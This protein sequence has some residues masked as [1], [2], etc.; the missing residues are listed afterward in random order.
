MN[1]PPCTRQTII[2]CFCPLLGSPEKKPVM[3]TRRFWYPL[4]QP[5]QFFVDCSHF[6]STALLD[7]C[8]SQY[9]RCLPTFG[10]FT[11]FWSMSMFLVFDGFHVNGFFLEFND[12]ERG[13][14]PSLSLSRKSHK[15]RTLFWLIL[16]KKSIT[17][18]F[19]RWYPFQI[20]PSVGQLR[21]WYR[22][23]ILCSRK[24]TPQP[25]PR[26]PKILQKREELWEHIIPPV[27]TLKYFRGPTVK[28]KPKH[29]CGMW[30]PWKGGLGHWYSGGRGYHWLSE[31]KLTRIR[32]I[33]ATR[34]WVAE[35]TCMGSKR[36]SMRSV[37]FDRGVTFDCL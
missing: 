16:Q 7:S 32:I 10:L 4:P 6:E 1:F 36:G 18:E 2:S 33:C 9:G 21:L 13:D 26:S 22:G 24:K 20:L 28:I 30:S 23:Q 17:C 5:R 27:P 15:H 25:R 34:G 11:P 12:G 19:G 14:I 35:M 3:W 8:N 37:C 29:D 31:R